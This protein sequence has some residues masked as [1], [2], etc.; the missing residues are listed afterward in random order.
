MDARALRD[1]GCIILPRCKP[2]VLIRYRK[3]GLRGES[4]LEKNNGRYYLRIVTHHL[5]NNILQVVKY[6]KP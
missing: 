3:P 1:S 2:S 4:V 6:I 5:D